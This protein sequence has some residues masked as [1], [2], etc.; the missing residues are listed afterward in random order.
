MTRG[1]SD[2]G[3]LDNI[4]TAASRQRVALHHY[5]KLELPGG[6]VY[7]SDY[8][9]YYSSTPPTPWRPIVLDFGLIPANDV[10]G[11]DRVDAQEWVLTL[12]NG[13]W[14][15][16]RISEEL[17]SGT[18]GSDAELVAFVPSNATFNVFFGRIKAIESITEWRVELRIAGRPS[19]LDRPAGR[20]VADSYPY[21]PASAAQRMQPYLYGIV[22]NVPLIPLRVGKIGRLASA[23]TSSATT[24]TLDS[25]L[26][27]WPTAPLDSAAYETLQIGDAELARYTSLDPSTREITV[28]ARGSEGTEGMAWPAGTIVMWRPSQYQ[29]LM[30]D[31]NTP[32]SQIDAVYVD[33][34]KLAANVYANE[35]L[36]VLSIESQ[37]AKQGRKFVTYWG[38]FSHNAMIT[39]N[40]PQ[41]IN[42]G[43][44]AATGFS[45]EFNKP[46]VNACHTAWPV[47]SSDT[48]VAW[49]WWSNNRGTDDPSDANNYYRISTVEMKANVAKTWSANRFASA[50]V[51]SSDIFVPES[52]IVETVL[53]GRMRYASRDSLN[54]NP[55]T[56]RL[57]DFHK[58]RAVVCTVNG[59]ERTRYLQP[60]DALLAGIRGGQLVQQLL[61][62]DFGGDVDPS[63]APYEVKLK[64]LSDDASGRP[65]A[66][67]QS[68]SQ[69]VTG[70]LTQVALPSVSTPT[71]GSWDNNY[72]DTATYHFNNSFDAAILT[73]A[74]RMRCDYVRVNL[75][76]SGEIHINGAVHSTNRPHELLPVSVGAATSGQP[77]VVHALLR[78][79][80]QGVS[81]TFRLTA[82]N[83]STGADADFA[84]DSIVLSE[85]S[86]TTTP[87]LPPSEADSPFILEF[88]AYPTADLRGPLDDDGLV[89][90]RNPADVLEHLLDDVMG[91]PFL[92]GLAGSVWKNTRT[93]L[94]GLG[95]K[96]DVLIPNQETKIAL[97]TRLA[98]QCRCML[99]WDPFGQ[100]VNGAWELVLR[101][102]IAD[103]AAG[104]ADHTVDRSKFLEG[105]IEIREESESDIVDVVRVQYLMDWSRGEFAAEATSGSGTRYRDERY[106]FDAVRLKSMAD[107]L[108][109]FYH[110]WDSV[111]KRRITLPLWMEFA[112]AFLME[113]VDLTVPYVGGGGHVAGLNGT[114]LV[115]ESTGWQAGHGPRGVPDHIPVV[116]VEVPT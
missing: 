1:V 85:L 78:R 4:A 8:H 11:G 64:V 12:W 72:T 69:G 55:G 44:A 111:A 80:V 32:I 31:A 98:R 22:P 13:P 53:N 5:V 112:Q 46:I 37:G 16:T 51:P 38:A 10:R 50:Y 104:S 28:S 90:L 25:D 33:G 39:T 29:F 61:S 40:G 77:A 59:V 21:A 43:P 7:V 48:T 99:R 18:L 30:A 58:I 110:G 88:G 91:E 71:G 86:L 23:I 89:V 107:D 65:V 68:L 92:S 108:A 94:E 17:A 2:W 84:V 34:K 24:L 116:L 75:P 62:F 41:M 83:M 105:D 56:V 66:Y 114:R 26:A 14:E 113:K 60:E 3:G 93:S 42:N 76:S 109:A 45:S 87:I 6:T 49:H 100:N 96:F 67:V 73:I 103:A 27:G 102:T 95:Y 82:T 15:G 63:Q 106:A 54:G 74:L 70:A 19:F 101:P 36:N 47:T 9:E 20:R 35:G 97:L 81:G 57:N 79:G 115:I 52:V